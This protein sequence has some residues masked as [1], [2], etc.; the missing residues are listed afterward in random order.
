MNSNMSKVGKTLASTIRTDKGF[1]FSKA[2]DRF[3][4]PTMKRQSPSPDRYFLSDSIGYDDFARTSPFK[5]SKNG[6][7]VFGREN[8]SDQFAQI[9]RPKEKSERPGPGSY[10]HYTQFNNDAKT[11][12]MMKSQ[13]KVP[14]TAGDEVTTYKM[15]SPESS[16]PRPPATADE[17]AKNLKLT[18]EQSA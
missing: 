5:T 17:A 11:E 13:M 4:A 15:K 14:V 9:L 18:T 16:S 8:R 3:L 12:S 1:G 7:A 6:R 10:C 2:N